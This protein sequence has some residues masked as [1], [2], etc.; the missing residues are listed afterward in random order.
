MK[1]IQFGDIDSQA[2][3]NAEHISAVHWGGSNVIHITAADRKYTHIFADTE[4]AK[5]VYWNNIVRNL[6]GE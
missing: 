3:Y 6:K 2:C 4:A 1:F 5:F